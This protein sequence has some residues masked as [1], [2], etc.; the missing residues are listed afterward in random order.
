[1]FYMGVYAYYDENYMEALHWYR[2]AAE[3]GDEQAQYNIGWMH[4]EGK[5]VEKNTQQVIKWYRK[6]A[7]HSKFPNFSYF[8]S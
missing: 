5:G 1:M 6:S 7:F 3:Q 8:C 4:E 2:L